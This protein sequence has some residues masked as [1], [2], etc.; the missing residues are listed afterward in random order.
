LNLKTDATIVAQSYLRSIL[1][2]FKFEMAL[3]V[4]CLC[5][6]PAV[7]LYVDHPELGISPKAGWA[8]A[9]ALLLIAIWMFCEGK[10]S[11]VILHHSRL[12][13]ITALEQLNSSGGPSAGLSTPS[14]PNPGSPF[15]KAPNWL[16]NLHRGAWDL[17]ILR[18]QGEWFEVSGVDA[19]GVP[20]TAW[21]HREAI[22][23]IWQISI[24]SPTLGGKSGQEPKEGG[25]SD[26]GDSA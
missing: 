7:W 5:S 3:Q 21:L 20:F 12:Q 1:L 18:Q 11:G 13:V 9:A 25:E 14:S 22:L 23:G 24:P 10:E 15:V 2:R 19:Q 16:G 17:S 4:V 26:E 8:I 6:L